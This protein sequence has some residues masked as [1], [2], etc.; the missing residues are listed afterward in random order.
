[1]KNVKQ[2]QLCNAIVKS[3][4][5][6]QEDVRAA[7]G[8][9][10]LEVGLDGSICGDNLY[11]VLASYYGVSKVTSVHADGTEYNGMWVAYV[12]NKE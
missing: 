1:M 9:P 7:F 12:P 6:Y 11:Q 8:D 10:D 3:F 2:Y 4:D 5:Q